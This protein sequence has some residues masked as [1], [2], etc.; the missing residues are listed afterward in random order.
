MLVIL[1][2]GTN[3]LRI[4]LECH[5]GSHSIGVDASAALTRKASMLVEW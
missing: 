5:P 4:R 3:G 2:N 1:T